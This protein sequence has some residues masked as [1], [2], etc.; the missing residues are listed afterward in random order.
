MSGGVSTTADFFLYFILSWC[1]VSYVHF[2]IE[3][4]TGANIVGDVGIYDCSTIIIGD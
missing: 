2:T 1:L 4:N 3:N